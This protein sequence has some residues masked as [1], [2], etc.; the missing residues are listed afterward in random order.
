MSNV[1]HWGT[2]EGFLIKFIKMDVAYI[3]DLMKRKS[4]CVIYCR[5]IADIFRLES[6]IFK[7]MAAVITRYSI[8]S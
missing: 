1:A 8:I 2:H 7:L 3:T 5:F 6:Q 4:A